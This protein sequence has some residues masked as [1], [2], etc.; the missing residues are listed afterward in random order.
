MSV[1]DDR[2]LRPQLMPRLATI[3]YRTLKL[4]PQRQPAATAEISASKS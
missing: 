2:L 3:A 1:F 4:L